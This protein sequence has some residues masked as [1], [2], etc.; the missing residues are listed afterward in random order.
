M[1]LGFPLRRSNFPS[2]LKL[3]VLWTRVAGVFS[4]SYLD[5]ELMETRKGI[6]C[7]MHNGYSYGKSRGTIEG[8][9]ECLDGQKAMFSE[10]VSTH[11]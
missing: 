6:C 9:E 7:V 3:I 1:S 10:M 8:S 2:A 5:K 11:R 4:L